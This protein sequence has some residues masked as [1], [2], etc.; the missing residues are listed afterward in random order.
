M[1][2]GVPHFYPLFGS[3][4]PVGITA[5]AVFIGLGFS[6]LKKLRDPLPFARGFFFAHLACVI[7]VTAVNLL[8]L[9]GI[10]FSLVSEGLHFLLRVVTLIGVIGL[11]L[12]CIPFRVWRTILRDT[13]WLWLYS[14]LAGVFVWSL[15]YLMQSS[16]TSSYTALGHF[17][18][19]SAFRSTSAVLRS[20]LPNLIVVP[21]DFTI[22]TPRFSVT[23]AEG[24]SGLEGLSL[25]SVFTVLWLWYF[26]KENRFPQALLLV[27]C[28]L[29]FV[30]MLNIVRISTLILIGNAGAQ[31]VAMMGFHSQAGWIAFT[32]VALS[33]SVAT[34]KLRWVRRE[35]SVAS[36]DPA[37]DLLS[38]SGTLPA[39]SSFAAKQTQEAGES[40][41]TAAYLV[42]FL[43]ILAASFVT[44]AASGH[45][46]WLYP[47]RFV[48]AAIAIWCYRSEFKKLEWRFSWFAPLTGASVF[49]LWIIPSLSAKTPAASTLG[50]SLAALSPAARWAWIA[51]RAAAAILTV[52][53]AEELAFRGYLARRW[54][55]LSNPNFETIS[56]SSVTLLS[57]ALS[58]IAFGLM[59]GKQWLVGILAGLAYAGIMK[60]KGRL[61]DAIIAHATTNL[62]LAA[63]VLLTGDW[64]Q[65]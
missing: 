10:G 34:R 39:S 46:E 5:F 4:A 45:F 11:A 36:P 9:R 22:G 18:Q 37:A 1:L 19:V 53:I 52:P 23:I 43:A 14:L 17:L 61:S 29:G 31:D 12:A 60:W 56:F 35:S 6:R 63:W 57:I 24:C 27:P 26:R 32:V 44:K 13:G 21:Q 47:L 25:V 8:A 7:L 55:K 48:A 64:S 15:R 42:P 30:W 58:S 38:A 41:A 65:W 33:F 3:L 40:P 2:A 59:H 51:F 54:I 62:L 50:A 20:I 16:D 49:A 28:A